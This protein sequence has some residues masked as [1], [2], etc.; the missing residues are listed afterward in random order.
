[1]SDAVGG[2]TVAA[3][4]CTA[5]VF[6]TDNSTTDAD[7]AEAALAFALAATAV[8]VSP[9]AVYPT[10]RSLSR[11]PLRVVVAAF[12]IVRKDTIVRTC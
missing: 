4:G 9:P 3:A 12:K 5:T 10:R 1:M 11:D 2:G 7:E 8:G 6:V